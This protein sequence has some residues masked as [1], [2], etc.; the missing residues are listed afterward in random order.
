MIFCRMPYAEQFPMNNGIFL[1]I[2]VKYKCPSPHGRCAFCSGF[3]FFLNVSCE[4]FRMINMILFEKFNHMF[5]VKHF[6]MEKIKKREIFKKNRC[7][8]LKYTENML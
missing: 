5:H 8:G 2:K 3:P 1:F 4:T 7:F 6:S